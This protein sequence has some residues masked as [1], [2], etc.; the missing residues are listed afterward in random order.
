MPLYERDFYAWT[1]KQA[2][3]LRS[4]QLA[5]LDIANVTWATKSLGS[6]AG[7]GYNRGRMR[8]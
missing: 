6:P 1:Q 2:D 8:G 3:L 4:G 5:Q 7:A